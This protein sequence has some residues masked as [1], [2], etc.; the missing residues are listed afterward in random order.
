M[1]FSSF[2]T[3]GRQVTKM[4]VL[5]TFALLA[6]VC[7][8]VSGDGHVS[9]TTCAEDQGLA[10]KKGG[11]F[12]CVDCKDDDVTMAT[13]CSGKKQTVCELWSSLGHCND[14]YAHIVQPRCPFMC[15]T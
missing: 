2:V 8:I 6:L 9:A 3:Y 13:S 11:G 7:S 5:I 12:V 15:G 14:Q 10:A 1:G 4:K